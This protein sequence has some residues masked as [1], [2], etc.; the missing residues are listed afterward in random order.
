MDKKEY[1]TQQ[2]LYEKEHV[3]LLKDGYKFVEEVQDPYDPHM[4]ISHF[5]KKGETAELFRITQ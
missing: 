5:K 1:E 3:R 4:W 2:R